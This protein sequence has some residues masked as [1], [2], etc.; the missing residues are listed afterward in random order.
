MA[1]RA[2]AQRLTKTKTVWC[3]AQGDRELLVLNNSSRQVQV[4]AYMLTVD[5]L[6]ELERAA[7]QCRE[8]I[9]RGDS[10]LLNPGHN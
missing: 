4:A 7:R 3:T 5:Q 6:C 1:T 9:T 2:I 8:L 10:T